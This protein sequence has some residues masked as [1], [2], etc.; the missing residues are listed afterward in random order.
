M[1]LQFL[2]ANISGDPRIWFEVSAVW[3][4]ALTLFKIK[5]ITNSRGGLAQIRKVI[6][7]LLLKF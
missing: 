7:D 3:G 2:A 5:P 4:T 1:E 6:S